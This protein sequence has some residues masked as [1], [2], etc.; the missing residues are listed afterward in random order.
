[1]FCSTKPLNFC[2]PYCDI[3]AVINVGVKF[4]LKQT[5]IKLTIYGPPTVFIFKQNLSRSIQCD[6]F[7]EKK[8]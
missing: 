4:Q 8:T 2:A 3:N 7:K 5:H 6:Q 1:M